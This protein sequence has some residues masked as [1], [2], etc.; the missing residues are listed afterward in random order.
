[1]NKTGKNQHEWGIVAQSYN[2]Y[3]EF[4]YC[5]CCRQYREDAHKMTKP[6]LKQIARE[7]ELYEPDSNTRFYI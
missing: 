5:P 4:I 6:Q 2:P 1:M 7:T 3:R